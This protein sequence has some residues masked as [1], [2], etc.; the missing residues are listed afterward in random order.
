MSR[1]TG[2]STAD[3]V[4]RPHRMRAVLAAAWTLPLIALAAC[5]G[6]AEASPIFG[7]YNTGVDSKGSLLATSA[8]DRHYSLTVNP[9]SQGTNAYVPPVIPNTWLAEGPSSNWIAPNAANPASAA[10]GWYTYQTT[11][12]LTGYQPATAVV[13]GRWATDNVGEAILL[14]GVSMG[15]QNTQ[16]FLAWTTFTLSSGFVSGVNT[17]AFQV[18]NAG[19]AP[20]PSGLRVEILAGTTATLI[21][22]P[23]PA[24]L[25]FL[26]LGGLLL[27]SRA[28]RRRR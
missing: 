8:I 26:A 11:F 24:T 21:P 14:N 1:E 17:L 15:L 22:V 25:S 2:S 7:L 19:T 27:I 20:N 5:A 6:T 28:V 12:D 13:V 16:Q 3:F 23:E 10:V 9:D 18:D 4:S